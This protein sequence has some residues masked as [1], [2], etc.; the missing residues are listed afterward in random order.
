MES[1]GETVP[2]SPDF[3]Q[4]WPPFLRR[5]F[6][7]LPLRLADPRG[8]AIPDRAL[9]F[10]LITRRDCLEALCREDDSVGQ[11]NSS[12][13]SQKVRQ[14]LLLRYDRD[15][16]GCKVEPSSSGSRSATKCLQRSLG[17]SLLR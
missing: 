4:T 1:R 7:F 2:S 3:T 17:A 12:G 9:I 10:S 6:S 5:F 15:Q 14:G 11:L 8:P 16:L 13:P